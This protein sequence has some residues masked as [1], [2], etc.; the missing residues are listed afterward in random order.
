MHY[1]GKVRFVYINGLSTKSYHLQS[2]TIVDSC[3]S[4]LWGLCTIH[5]NPIFI[6]DKKHKAERLLS[7][8]LMNR[9]M[10]T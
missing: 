1:S 7:Y 6:S 4:G 9:E 8:H 10:E 5:I 3:V 2:A